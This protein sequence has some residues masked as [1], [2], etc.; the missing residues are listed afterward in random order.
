[1]TG[2]ELAAL[3]RAASLSQTDLGRLAGL[4]RQTVSYWERK[5]KVDLRAHALRQIGMIL[6]LPPPNR[7]I[8]KL[9]AQAFEEPPLRLIGPLT[10]QRVR[11][12]AKTR[13][14]T[15]CAAMS[16]PNKRRCKF[17]GGM[18]T[19][20]KTQEGRDRIAQAQRDRWAKR[21]ADQPN[22]Q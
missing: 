10:G 14:G 7:P 21:K 3:R 9:W 18:S 17:H 5:P 11:C 8:R 15:P 2:A 19:G 20:P 16:L 12:G 6:A 1:M 22:G 13:K 4:G